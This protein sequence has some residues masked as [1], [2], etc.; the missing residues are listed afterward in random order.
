ME[1]STTYN[2]NNL[3]PIAID[4]FA[5]AGGLG[6]GFMLGG[7]DVPLSVEVDQWACDTLR[8]NHP[9][10]GVLQSDIRDCQ[11]SASIKQIC[12]QRPDIIIGGPPCQ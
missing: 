10:M 9:K 5:D 4:L 2:S 8:Y 12:P 6:L 3:R 1:L 11:D 7:F